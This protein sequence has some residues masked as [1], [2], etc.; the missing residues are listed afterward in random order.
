[1]DIWKRDDIW[2]DEKFWKRRSYIP[3]MRLS[4][5]NGAKCQKYHVSVVGMWVMH[6][7][8][9]PVQLRG[10]VYVRPKMATPFYIMVPNM[11]LWRH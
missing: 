4:R 3:Y 2:T 1:V 10:V 11:A 8:A 7:G 9:E 5:N 6:Y